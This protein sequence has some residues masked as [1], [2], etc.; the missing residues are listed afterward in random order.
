MVKAVLE[1]VYDFRQKPL[2]LL[3]LSMLELFFSDLLVVEWCIVE[4]ILSFGL[5]GL[6]FILGFTYLGLLMLQLV[7]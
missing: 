2:Q 4:I 5:I 1:R 7:H 6:K 3:L